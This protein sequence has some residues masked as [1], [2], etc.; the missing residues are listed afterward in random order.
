MYKD[1]KI[2]HI[3]AADINGAIGNENKLLWNIPEDLKYFRETTLGHVVLMG[4]N[5]IESLPKKLSRRVVLEVSQKNAYN[6][7]GGF[8]EMPTHEDTLPLLLDVAKTRSDMLN[9]DC[10]FIAGGSKL[11]ESTMDIVDEVLLTRVYHEFNKFDSTYNLPDSIEGMEFVGYTRENHRIFI[12]E[13]MDRSSGS[14]VAID[15]PASVKFEKWRKV[16]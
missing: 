7:V 8:C 11:Y 1:K 14:S 15:H 3:V 16:R 10:I 12:R 13:W 9:T 6:F 5:T 2:I 4:R